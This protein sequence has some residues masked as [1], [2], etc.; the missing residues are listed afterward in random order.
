MKQ[1]KP[2]DMADDAPEETV[3][4]EAIKAQAR[5][6]VLAELEKERLAMEDAEAKAALAEQARHAEEAEALRKK[7]VPVKLSHDY[8][9]GRDLEDQWITT[10]V[11]PDGST[12]RI[13]AGTVVN[14]PGKDARKLMGDGKAERADPLP[15]EI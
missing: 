14:L 5:A 4:V 8:W 12:C 3:D 2:T 10:N 15:D 11:S 1:P 9:A 7:R 6:E 13:P